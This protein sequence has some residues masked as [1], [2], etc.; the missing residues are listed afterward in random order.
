GGVQR[1]SADGFGRF[2]AIRKWVRGPPFDRLK[3]SIP[4]LRIPSTMCAKPPASPSVNSLV[5]LVV[6]GFLIHSKKKGYLQPD[7]IDYY[8]D[9]LP[10]IFNMLNDPTEKVRMGSCYA[11]EAFCEYLGDEI[12]PYLEPLMTKMVQLL[13]V[14]NKEIQELAISAISSA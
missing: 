12:I 14:N 9:V 13:Q 2:D 8:K 3:S 4:H 7:I 5:C 1:F 10:S 6:H 11:L